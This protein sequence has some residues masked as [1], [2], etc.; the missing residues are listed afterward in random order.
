MNRPLKVIVIGGGIGG[1]STA[2]T[3]EK[4][5]CEVELYEQATEL[6]TAGSGLS[7]M[8]NAAVALSTLGIDLKLGKFGAPIRHFEIRSPN[9]KLIRNL[10]LPEISDENGADSVCISRKALQQ[11]LLAQV[12]STKIRTNSKVVAVAENDSGVTVKFSN[13]SSA[14]GDILIG[15]DGIHSYV[16]EVLQGPQ[17]VRPADYICWLAITRFKHP[18]ITPGYVGHYWGAGKRIG[19]IDVGGGEVYWWGTANMRNR[20]AKKWKGNATDILAF[21][22]GWPSIVSEIIS[23]TSD[24]KIISVPAQDKD[25]S[26]A[27]GKGRITLLGDAAHPMLTSLGQGAGMAIEDAAVL[28]HTLRDC[29]DPVAALRQ[30]EEIR[31]PRAQMLVNASKALSETEQDDRYFHRLKRDFSLKWLPQSKLKQNLKSSLD[32]EAEGI[33]TSASA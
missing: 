13:G 20:D 6:R 17:S 33:L 19:L 9:D 22:E 7:V 21:Y 1:L 26:A 10:P 28:A 23:S 16:R 32:F 2:V 24:D 18:Q 4:V 25:F 3:L 31:I 30:Y 11:A 15:A 8:S 29:K 12:D 27:W 14:S 5:G